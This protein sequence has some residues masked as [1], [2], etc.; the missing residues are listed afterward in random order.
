MQRSSTPIL[1]LAGLAAFGGILYAQAWQYL[2]EANVDGT[3]DHD[4]ISV[5]Q[6][7]FRAIRLRV[8]NGPIKFDHVVVH[9]NN[10]DSDP[11]AIPTVIQPGGQTRVINLPGAPRFVASVEFWYSRANP[12]SPKPKVRLYGVK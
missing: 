5:D 4:R 12:N 1:L 11:I 2:G 6:G 8:E 10:G 7:A 9:F 3:N